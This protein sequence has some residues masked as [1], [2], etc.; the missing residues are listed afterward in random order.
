MLPREIHIIRC[1]ANLR[2]KAQKALRLGDICANSG[3]PV[4]AMRLW[5]FTLLLIANTD[6]DDWLCEPI[7]TELFSLTSLVS[8]AEAEELGRRIDSLWERLGHPEM[9]VYE[10][11]A[12]AEYDY[13][14][15]E[16]YDYCPSAYSW[17]FDEPEEDT[18]LE[19]FADGL[20]D[21]HPVV[22]E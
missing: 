1:A 22:L 15:L 17:L 12:T 9:G 16:K 4:W 19:V 8:Q 14:W 2:R 7:N 5:L 3:H 11:V 21:W 13:L 18:S 6:Y 20:P 10:D